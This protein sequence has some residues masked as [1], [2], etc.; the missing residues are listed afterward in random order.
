M[1]EKTDKALLG[2]LTNLNQTLSDSQEA[3]GE[4]Q[5][6][7]N[8]N[9]P[10]V[11]EENQALV[12]QLSEQ[13]TTTNDKLTEL[14]TLF[15]E[16][17]ETINTKIG[18]FNGN[19][20]TLS[21]SLEEAFTELLEPVDEAEEMIDSAGEA[22]NDFLAGSSEVLNQGIEG[23]KALIENLN[24]EV[25]KECQQFIDQQGKT[26]QKT[27]EAQFIDKADQLMTDYETQMQ[28][29]LEQLIRK[30]MDTYNEQLKTNVL[31]NVKVQLQSLAQL[32]SNILQSA[33]QELLATNEESRVEREL[34]EPLI[35]QLGLLIDPVTGIVEAVEDLA[36][37][38]GA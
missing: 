12:D 23:I 13:V 37:S 26:L 17:E 30:Q 6:N 7:I 5:Q 22:I 11:I 10:L 31:N 14:K 15:T 3:M 9:L 25:V 2:V 28:Q 35:E 27:F 18:D 19:M 36:N 20:Q 4:F 1:S 21:A 16:V 29:T 24:N 32:F 38:V 33:K 8:D 34:L